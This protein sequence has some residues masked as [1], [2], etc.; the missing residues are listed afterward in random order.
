MKNKMVLKY[1]Y[2]KQCDDK[3]ITLWK[4][5]IYVFELPNGW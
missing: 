4:I 2:K 5:G 1:V 3:Y